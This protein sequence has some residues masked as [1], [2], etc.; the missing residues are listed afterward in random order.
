MSLRQGNINMIYTISGSL[1][2]MNTGMSGMYYASTYSDKL[3]KKNY[4]TETR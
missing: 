4:A 3:D 1:E 2:G